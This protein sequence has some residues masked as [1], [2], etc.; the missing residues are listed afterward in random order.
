MKKGLLLRACLLVILSFGLLEGA[1]SAKII[2]VDSDSLTVSPDGATWATAF[3]YLQDALSAAQS[4]DEIWVAEGTYEPD[5]GAGQTPADR[6]ASF[7]LKNGVALYGGFSGTENVRSQ[8]NW[9]SHTTVLGGD[10]GTPGNPTDNSFHVVSASHVS[11][12][13]VL[14]GF[15]ITLGYANGADPNNKGGGIFIDGGSPTVT[16]CVF[17]GNYA[18]FGGGV[19]ALGTNSLRLTN[20]LFMNNSS[21]E[22]EG[23]YLALG[24]DTIL[25]NCVF[26]DDQLTSADSDTTLINCTLFKDYSAIHVTGYENDMRSDL[27]LQNCI[28][29]GD[30]GS[31]KIVTNETGDLSMI[32]LTID[33]NVF[34]GGEAAI[35]AHGPTTVDFTNNLAGNPLLVNPDAVPPN[36]R[37]SAGSPAIDA[38]DNSYVPA[39]LADLDSDGNNTEPVPLDPDGHLRFTDNAAADTGAGTAPLVDIGAY[40]HNRIIHVDARAT[41]LNNGTS[42]GNAFTNL[43]DA[44]AAA[45]LTPW[46][47]EIWVAAGVYKPDQGGTPPVNT[48]KA[49]FQLINDAALYGGFAGVE[50]RREERNWRAYQTVLSGDIG[51]EDISSDNAYHVVTASGVN[52]T[53]ILNGFS[54]KHGYADGSSPDNEGGGLYNSGGS[55]VVANC[56]FTENWA[57]DGGGVYNTGGN[58]RYVNCSFLGNGAVA[59]GGMYN[60]RSK[61]DIVNAVF[62]GNSAQYGGGLEDWE[63]EWTTLVNCTFSNNTAGNYAGAVNTL[64]G[65]GPTTMENCVLWGNSAP[66]GPQVA[67]GASFLAYEYCDIQGGDSGIFVEGSS[68]VEKGEGNIAE[69]PLFADADGA[70]NIAG[71]EDDNPRLSKGSDCVDTGGSK[72]LPPDWADL[73]GDGNS[74]EQTPVDA[75]GRRRILGT[76]DMGAYEYGPRTIYVDH[77]A[78]GHNDG[79]SWPNAFARLQD[80]LAAALPEDDLWVARGTY[81]ADHGGGRTAGDRTASFMLR[82]GVSLYGGFSGTETSRSQRNWKTN[83]TTLS[84]DLGGNDGANFTNYEDNSHHVVVGS[85]TDSTTVLD[86]FIISGGHA[87]AP[88]FEYPQ[89]GGAGMYNEAG[90][91]TISNCIFENNLAEV[92]GGGG[93][94]NHAGSSPQISHVKFRNNSAGLDGSGAGIYNAY[95]SNPNLTDCLFKDN[96]GSYGGAMHNVYTSVVTLTNC[97]FSGN[98]ASVRGGAVRSFWNS[99]L[100]VINTIFWGDSGPEGPEIALDNGSRMTIHYSDLDGGQAMIYPPGAS[101]TWGTGTIDADPRFIDADLHLRTDSPCIDA[102]DP[103]YDYSQEPVPNGSRINMG[104]YGNTQEAT[105]SDITAPTGSVLI[106][107]GATYSASLSVTLAL[108]CIDAESGCYQMRFS[109]NNSVWSTWEAWGT[110]KA[111]DLAG[112]NGTTTVYVQYRNNSGL[113]SGSFSDS[114]ILDATAPT[115]GSLLATEG[116]AEVLLNWFGFTDSGGIVSYTLVYDTAPPA[117]N[118]SS[119]TVLY[120][121]GLDTSFL[122]NTGLVPG[123]PYYYRVCASDNAG[124]IS[125]GATAEGVPGTEPAVR[126][127]GNG[128]DFMSIQSVYDDPQLQN[129]DLIQAR[130]TYFLETLIFDRDLVMVFEGGYDPDYSDRNSTTYINGSLTISAGTVTIDRLVLM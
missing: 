41:G 89:T 18:F 95:S 44:L 12:S 90:S 59:G 66:N 24:F 72:F 94:L 86:G 81:K 48:R 34:M 114:I 43:Q 54:V 4:G 91:P 109:N 68:K 45:P 53:A 16:N 78:G 103:T 123:T 76:V 115:N 57:G 102:G 1:A 65:K 67:V 82:T 122:Q 5:Q 75:D 14:D 117:V 22:N 37:L 28:V 8:R 52:A 29:W 26:Y 60:Y 124:N 93:I 58:S 31:A 11:S 79:S 3:R 116:N 71:T 21:F 112:G 121:G 113:T 96:S 56:I 30:T 46:A 51:T 110:S 20:C 73:D 125:S 61:V 77:L 42:W 101:V 40:E 69:D 55:P 17:E 63:A 84:G 6:F 36:L 32:F 9:Q 88:G 129:G 85:G 13:A 2:R 80:A 126:I 120:S 119:G 74:S 39:D 107:A 50:T 70:D 100:T 23:I 49:T 27:R 7:S 128:T 62:S 10:V 130:A 98:T 15:R 97:T 35:E 33:R 38:G 92:R 47:D 64:Y 83:L 104:A 111:W 127:E 106:N 108:S 19:Y 25:V 87:N 118:C 105:I 99:D